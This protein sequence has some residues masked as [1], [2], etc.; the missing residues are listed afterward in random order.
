M[1][2]SRSRVP[3]EGD[4]VTIDADHTQGRRAPVA[5]VTRVTGTNA[6]VEVLSTGQSRRVSLANLA[7]KQCSAK[8]GRRSSKKSKK[9]RRK[10]MK[11]R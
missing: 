7:Y 6:T 10:T 11:L 5:R 2:G 1:S 8:G 9:S 4:C 3:R